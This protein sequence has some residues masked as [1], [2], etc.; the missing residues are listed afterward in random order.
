MRSRA[1]PTFSRAPSTG[2]T[3]IMTSAPGEVLRPITLNGEGLQ[4]GTEYVDK[5]E[6]VLYEAFFLNVLNLPEFDGWSS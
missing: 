2:S 5:I 3:P 4:W 1:A 6:R